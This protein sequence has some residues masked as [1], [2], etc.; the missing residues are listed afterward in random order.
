[1]KHTVPS[2]HGEALRNVRTFMQVCEY[3]VDELGWPLD[4]SLL[5]DESLSNITFELDPS[6]LGIAPDRLKDLRRLQQMR[7]L[8]AGQ[9]W[10][11]FFMEFDGMR[12]PRMQI[13]R[14]LKTLVH[15]K[16][17]ATSPES[18]TW[19]LDDLLFVVVTG[20]DDSV[21][22]H[23]LAFRGRDA[24]NAKFLSLSW[25]PAQE[26]TA[27]LRR[28]GEELLPHLLWPDRQDDAE[29]WRDTWWKAFKLPD[30][31]AIRDSARLAERMAK[32][33]RDLRIQIL[34]EL[35][36]ERAR[37]RAGRGN[38]RGNIENDLLAG[39]R[40]TSAPFSALMGEI[41]TQLV[42]DVTRESFSDMCAQTLVYGTL[43]SRVTSPEDFGSSPIFS[44]VP[45]GNPFLE[46][47]FERVHDQVVELNLPGSGLPKLVAD[48]RE[49]N[50]EHILDQ[51]GS[52]AKGGDPVIHFY[53]EFLKQ[54]NSKM[55][56]DAGAFYTPQ[57]AV[58]FTVR[59]TDEVLRTRFS[60]PLGIADPSSWQEV[61]ARND[62]SVPEGI[63]P[64]KPFVS[65]VD[66][67]TG[68]GTFLVEWLR[69][70]RMS[71]EQS[72]GPVGWQKHLREHVLGS[73]HAFE[74]M[75]APYAIAH[76]KVA[77]E[78]HDAGAYD[79][80]G[81]IQ[82]LLTNTL[83]HAA[84]QGQFET[85]SDP[86]AQEGERAANL[87]DNERFTV[88][89]GNP[90]YDRQQKVIGDTGKSKGGVVRHGAAGI[91][92]LLKA[93]L[94]PMKA[95]GH[96]GHLKNVYNDYIY[97]WRWAIWQATELP[98]GPG[99]VAFITASSYLDGISMG[100]VRDLL[101]NTFDELW[102]VDL[103]G[104]G[105]GARKED[106]IFDIQT[107]VAIAVGVRTGMH[108]TGGCRVRYLRITGTRAEKLD[109]LRQ[110]EL[111]D[112]S[113]E[114]SG[115][116]LDRMVPRSESQYYD[117][118]EITDLF[119]WIRSGCKLGR[120]WPI[121]E[122]RV[123]LKH[124]WQ[125]LIS[126]VPR[127]RNELFVDTKWGQKTTS[128]PS[129][130]LSTGTKLRS[131]EH[132]DVG[133]EPE[134][135][136]RYGYRSF[137]RQWIIADHRLIDRAGPYLWRVRGSRQ[138]FLTTLTSTKLGR[139]PML[140]ATP[141]V[142]DL[143]HFSG[144]GAKNIMPLHRDSATNEPN[145]T[146][147]LL[148]TLDEILGTETTAQDLF[149]YVY[150]LGGTPAF[151]ECFDKELAEQAGPFHVPITADPNL[152]QQAVT[153]G[154]DLLWWHTWG[155][156]FAPVAQSHLP[157]GKAKEIT[158]VEGMPD[159]FHYDPETQRLTVGTGVFA[160]IS[161][162]AWDFEVSGLKVLR[163][164]LSYRMKNRKGRKSSPL[165]DIRPTRWTQTNELLL[166][167]SI[168]EHTIE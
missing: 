116:G 19:R 63:D 147:D 137:D 86:V 128:Q 94:E 115:V 148:S 43:S 69:R 92:P 78:L 24:Q 62:F 143:D 154:R 31:Q 74:L 102:I 82:I 97:F 96:G 60:L 119:P 91:E 35:E 109:H 163:S 2:N 157:D 41:R 138:V 71:F 93:V 124:R 146:Q 3:F 48:L 152:F 104:E 132:L 113:D 44:T 167:L 52:T 123:P 53:E 130:L 114:I 153:L 90:P 83:E 136:E 22:L 139:G 162:E 66:P 160:P 39:G 144:R 77:L 56:A 165:D 125:E 5:D 65:M 67:A 118:P 99:V 70:A 13:R 76:L 133:D 81:E 135:Y 50:V 145:V 107:P 159:A 110:L 111:D 88:V 23:L 84:R 47:F 89:I 80:D 126:V 6:E 17:T 68:T 4:P 155:E 105:R 100:G 64:A 25:R 98:P 33:A 141:Y 29:S 151:G 158:P 72:H 106:N 127:I 51:I 49:T 117:W 75:L 87:K 164:W 142:P 95:A 11:V 28:L 120:T 149:S 45:L 40:A 168:I 166:V 26:P 112:I 156:R 79:S 103:G 58:E 101:R 32:T 134:G 30:G 12:L 46:A 122:V 73:M 121:S 108:C 10:G 131:V 59:M 37:E 36:S 55:R 61:A 27:H 15:R 7:P 34:E 9:P 85:M 16:R 57:P 21:A 1:M 20:A 129:P 14:L 8:T 140:T 18:R 54:Y 150:S 161:P 42:N 38:N